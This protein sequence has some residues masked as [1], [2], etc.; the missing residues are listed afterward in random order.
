MGILV[1]SSVMDDAVRHLMD[2]EF[3]RVRREDAEVMLTSATLSG[4]LLAELRGLPGVLGAEPA[5][6]VPVWLHGPGGRWEGVLEGRVVTGEL[7]RQLDSRGRML[8]PP[9]LGGLVLTRELG[10]RLGVR[11]GEAVALERL[12]ADRAVHDVA[13]AGF[14][15]E[16]VGLHASMGLDAVPRLL[17]GDTVATGALL[18]LDPAGESQAIAALRRRPD[19][20]GVALRR[21][22]LQT[23][24]RLMAQSSPRSA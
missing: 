20:A 23:F 19:V 8:P 7:R 21:T 22:A 5:R 2:V 15:D 3:R 1:V 14:S 11:A 6:V 17:G 24:E 16:A 18:A 12:D 4:P 10:R 9:P 13:V